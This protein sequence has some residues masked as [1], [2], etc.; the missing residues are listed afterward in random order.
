LTA[1]AAEPEK[2]KPLH[3]PIPQKPQKGSNFIEFYEIGGEALPLDA[4][5]TGLSPVI[6][7]PGKMGEATSTRQI[8]PPS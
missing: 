8:G 1:G 6:G 2:R 5:Y 7:V 3:A 4:E